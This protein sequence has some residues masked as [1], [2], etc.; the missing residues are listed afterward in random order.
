MT[1][2]CHQEPK[3][4][5]KNVKDIA[6][7]SKIEMTLGKSARCGARRS[8]MVRSRVRARIKHPVEMLRGKSEVAAELLLVG[9][10]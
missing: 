1:D 2:L 7:G 9:A 4:L 8:M 10:V 3:C 5:T 6:S